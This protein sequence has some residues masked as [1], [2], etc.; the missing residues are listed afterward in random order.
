V[1]ARYAAAGRKCGWPARVTRIYIVTGA[2]GAAG[3]Q[4]VRSF[5]RAGAN[6]A[7]A[8]PDTDACRSM[9]DALGPRALCVDDDVGTE[10]GW[11]QAYKKTVERFGRVDGVVNDG[12]IYDPDLLD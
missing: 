12:S 10:H 7:L 9:A 6:V 4:H 2:T 5:I 8:D 11:W 3:Q 1:T